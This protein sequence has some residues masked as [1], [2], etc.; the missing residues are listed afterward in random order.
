MKNCERIFIYFIS[1]KSTVNSV[2]I[3]LQQIVDNATI[4]NSGSHA[5]HLCHAFAI[6][7]RFGNNLFNTRLQ[8]F[9]KLFR[10]KRRLGTNLH[11][12]H[13]NQSQTHFNYQTKTRDLLEPNNKSDFADEE[14]T[15]LARPWRRQL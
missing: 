11:T 13:T 3:T 9:E 12:K 10:I 5:V 1:S 14:R 4:R 2:N 6:L 7:E 15:S 8:I